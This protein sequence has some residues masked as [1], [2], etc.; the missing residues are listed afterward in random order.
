[1]HG[2]SP[3]QT[4]ED[5][6]SVFQCLNDFRCLE[7]QC[8]DAASIAGSKEMSKEDKKRKVPQ[9]LMAMVLA[10]L[11]GFMRIRVDGYD[12]GGFIAKSY[13]LASDIDEHSEEK[14]MKSN[15]QKVKSRNE[16]STVKGDSFDKLVYKDA[17]EKVGIKRAAFHSHDPQP[18]HDLRFC[19]DLQVLVGHDHRAGW[20]RHVPVCHDLLFRHDLRS[21]HDLHAKREMQQPKQQQTQK[22]QQLKQK[23]H[24]Q[25]TQKQ[26]QHKQQQLVL[27]VGFDKHQQSVS[28][29]SELSHFAVQ[30]MTEKGAPKFPPPCPKVPVTLPPEMSPPPGVPPTP[31]AQVINTENVDADSKEKRKR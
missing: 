11:L 31:I 3:S 25:R 19:Y 16:S 14:L 30:I 6:K 2:H 21:V 18:C 20:R 15:G 29:S 13:L 5:S 7:H 8:Y 9:F 4:E 1:M 27:N 23:H 26:Q 12:F 17:H 10:V 28:N 22:P 24:E